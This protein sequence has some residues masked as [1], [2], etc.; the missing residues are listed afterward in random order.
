M[1]SVSEILKKALALHQSGDFDAAEKGYRQILRLDA[2]HAD[3]LHLLG[4]TALQRNQDEE[5]LEWFSAAIEESDP[6]ALLYSNLGSAYRNL[7]RLEEAIDA[8]RLSIR[9]SPEFAGVHFNLAM[10]L[11]SVGDIDAS[12]QEYQS[13]IW[14]N[15]KYA[16]ARCRLGCLLASQGNF[17]AAI[18]HLTEADRLEPRVTKILSPLAEA[19][20][21]TNRVDEAKSV[22]RKI[23]R[24]DPTH[25]SARERLIQLSAA[26]PLEQTQ[27]AHAGSR[28]S[29]NDDESPSIENILKRARLLEIDARYDES[30]ECYQSVLQENPIHVFANLWLGRHAVELGQLEKAVSYLQQATVTN[31]DDLETQLQLGNVLTDLEREPEAIEHF[32]RAAEFSPQSALAW[33]AMGN[34]LK[35]LEQ[36]EEAADCYQK[37]IAI[38]PQFHEATHNL[39]IVLRHLKKHDEAVTCFGRLIDENM[40][41][42]SAHLQRALTWLSMGRLKEGWREYEW[43]WQAEF[44]G[45]KFSQPTW[46]GSSLA[47]KSILVH[48]EQ[49]VGD[50]IQFASC[51]PELIKQAKHCT[52]ECDR[53][54]VPLYARSFP[55]CSVLAGPLDEDAIR[56][57]YDVQIPVGSLPRYCRETFSRFPQ[58][59][60]Y[61]NADPQQVT[62]WRKRFQKMGEGMTVGISWKGGSKRETIHSRS[63]TLEQWKQVFDV[64]N[65]QFINL[66][67]GD[68]RDERNDCQ[69]QFGV[70]IHTWD[71]EDHFNNLD[72][73]ASEIS[74][75]DLVVSIDNF[76]VHLAGALGVPTWNL[77]PYAADYRWMFGTARSPWYP[78]LR[79]LR[80]QFP[81]EWSEVFDTVAKRI[82]AMSAGN[83]AS[84]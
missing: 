62:E 32:R 43:R 54:L 3:A 29:R 19:Q 33:Y 72:S 66:Q 80:Q 6:S 57:T 53:R 58:K 52:I 38:D 44:R 51:L 64:P 14:N 26:D 69:Q 73:L 7:N 11:E 35:N 37:T 24:I 82:T 17:T 4:V 61:L 50:E 49:G 36:Y 12:I 30:A 40:S 27:H 31:P 15:P 9:L 5:A 2:K 8:F 1:L 74:A 77:L 63:T 28:P 23:L 42:A 34:L 22:L 81:G 39:G 45:R 67:Y 55:S 13:A 75:L 78:S 20:I 84:I 65:I 46:D 56:N 48:A 10:A 79:L 71:D 25:Q 68:V 16:E 70:T 41:D 76:T 83:S 18:D 60:G 59:E 47:G 21:A